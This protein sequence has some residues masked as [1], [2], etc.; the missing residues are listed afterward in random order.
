MKH[1]HPDPETRFWSRVKLL[2]DG[3][4]L[5]T[6]SAQGNGTGQFGA[7]S[8]QS[9]AHR[10]AWY[11]VHGSMPDDGVVLAHICGNTWCINVDH[12]EETT[13]A[14]VGKRRKNSA[15]TEALHA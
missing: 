8:M 7:N 6:G 14:E 11:F 4:L 13:K 3:C 10:W 15:R 2:A 9:T 1:G 5:W 12:L